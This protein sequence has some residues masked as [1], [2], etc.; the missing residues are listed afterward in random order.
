MRNLTIAALFVK[1]EFLTARAV[2][3]VVLPFAERVDGLAIAVPQVCPSK[4]LCCIFSQNM[5]GLSV[6]WIASST[7]L[8][9]YENDE[10]KC[11]LLSC[12]VPVLFG[13]GFCTVP[14]LPARA[15]R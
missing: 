3:T 2:R 15:V 9:P 6:I 8:V 4:Y 13:N 14:L 7:H 12:A 1:R 11:R 5:I 10:I